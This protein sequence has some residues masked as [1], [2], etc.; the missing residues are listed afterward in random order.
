MKLRPNITRVGLFLITY[1]RLDYLKK[2]LEALD[3]NNWGGANLRGIVDDG[4]NDGTS[5]F[6]IEY[7]KENDAIII[8]KSG[9]MGV[10]DSKNRALDYMYN[11]ACTEMFTI[12]DDIIMKDR[13]TCIKYVA[14]ARTRGLEHMNFALHGPL[15][16]GMA[17]IYTWRGNDLHCYPNVTGAFTYISKKCYDEVG[18]YDIEFK[19]T[20]DHPFYTLQAAKK[21]MHPP[22][23]K[24][25]DHPKNHEMLEEIE[26]SYRGTTIPFKDR[27][28]NLKVAKELWIKKEGCWITDI[29]KIKNK[30]EEN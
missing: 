5:D 23:W 2:S 18:G 13:C 3:N 29:K 22:F 26:G 8:L 7:A 4:S 30:K 17:F 21:G 19:N 1:N 27:N 25:V 12:E 10:A 11:A 20:M 24:F 16:K 14:H 9:N 28:A 15:N 6:L